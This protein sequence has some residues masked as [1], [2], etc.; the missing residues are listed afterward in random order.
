VALRSAPENPAAAASEALPTPAPH[1][2]RAAAFLV[3]TALVVAL[4]FLLPGGTPWI[5]L[6][7]LFVAYHTVFTWLV[8]RTVGKTTFSLSVQRVDKRPTVLWAFGRSPIS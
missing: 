1:G 8:Q 2:L 5:A 6:P 7:L 4:F 3:D